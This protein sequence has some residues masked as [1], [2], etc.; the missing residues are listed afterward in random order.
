[1]NAQSNLLTLYCCFQ[2]HIIKPT[3]ITN[4]S[5][6]LIDHIYFNSLEHRT[7]SGNLLWDISDHLPNF[8]IINELS[9]SY[10][11]PMIYKRDYSSYKEEEFLAEIQSVNWEEVF[12][13]QVDIEQLF[14]SF[15]KKL[16]EIV[17]KHVPLK[18]VS[19]RQL[20]MQFKP[21][22]KKGIRRSISIKNKLYK[23]Y[24]ITKNDYYFSKYKSYRNRI[25]HLI[26][27]SKRSFY[28]RYFVINRNNMKETW[29]RIKQINNLKTTT[30]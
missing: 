6:T 29:K 24:S 2:S 4:H 14:N 17:Y 11:K 9:C 7:V 28:N 5:T 27:L 13:A 18:R 16:T 22:I 30:H 12:P 3:R 26:L 19:K 1:M 23:R 20:K 15:H 21:W 10:H 25:K 8:L